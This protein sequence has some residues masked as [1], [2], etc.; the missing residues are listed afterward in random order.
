[1]RKKAKKN[2]EPRPAPR[3]AQRLGKLLRKAAAAAEQ[4]RKAEE[5]Q[6]RID[7]KVMDE[8]RSRLQLAHA[9]LT[10]RNP[11]YER[12]TRLVLEALRAVGDRLINREAAA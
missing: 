6:A 2:G 12:V 3:A 7:R 11:D 5:S 10:D 9:E 8:V 4:Y 1:V